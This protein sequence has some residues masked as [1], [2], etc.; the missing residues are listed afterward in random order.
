MIIN[1]LKSFKA[2]YPVFILSTLSKEMVIREK[3]DEFNKTPSFPEAGGRACF[4]YFCIFRP[5]HMVGTPCI[6]VELIINVKLSNSNHNSFTLPDDTWVQFDIRV[7]HCFSKGLLT[8]NSR[9]WNGEL[10]G[11]A[12][13]SEKMGDCLTVGITRIS[14]PRTWRVWLAWLA[15]SQNNHLLW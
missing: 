2:V 13:Y 3:L 10:P 6:F 14:R 12:S 15:D 1:F 4:I 8:K 5:K 9:G 11:P 7:S